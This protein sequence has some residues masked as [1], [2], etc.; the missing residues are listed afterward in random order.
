MGTRHGEVPH[1]TIDTAVSSNQLFGGIG[2][3]DCPEADAYLN[4]TRSVRLDVV[5][6]FYLASRAWRTPASKGSGS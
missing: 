5:T 1:P 3:A 6:G 4:P 2:V